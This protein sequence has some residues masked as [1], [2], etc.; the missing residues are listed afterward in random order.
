MAER[1]RE[2]RA[3][4]Q[5]QPGMDQGLVPAPENAQGVAQ[6]VGRIGVVRLQ[7]QRAAVELGR[8]GHAVLAHARARQVVVRGRLRRGAGEDAG[9][10]VGGGVSQAQPVAGERQVE[11]ALRVVR[12][13][14][15]AA[16]GRDQ[17]GRQIC[18]G[19]Q[20]GAQVRVRIG[21]AGR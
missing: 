18:R 7:L 6:P 3:Q 2:I 21:A 5:R 14:L 13:Q 11:Q 10:R 17:G 1:V 15:E 8:L 12:N 19:A 9:E 4:L 20:G 16:P